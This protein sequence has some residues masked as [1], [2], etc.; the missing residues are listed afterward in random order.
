VVPRQFERADQNN[1]APRIGIAWDPTGTGRLSLRAGSGLFYDRPS[2][3]IYLNSSLNTPV[4]ARATASVLTPPVV[5]RF[6]LGRLDQPPYDFPLPPGVGPGLNEQN[7]LS[8]GARVMLVAADPQ[9]RT[10]YAVNWFAGVQYGLRSDWSVEANYL[11]S[12]GRRLYTAP[13]VNRFAGDLIVNNGVQQRLNRSFAEIEYGQ[14][15]GTSSFHGATV[16]VHKRFGSRLGWDAAYTFGKAI[17]QT[18]TFHPVG[19]AQLAVAEPNDLRRQRGLADFDV[20]HRWT[21]N[22]LW[23]LPAPPHWTAL[24]GGWQLSGVTMIQ[25][26]LPFSVVCTRP[27]AAVRD[28]G[29]RI[30]GNN[31]CDY[32]AD[33]YA[34]D[35]PDA[36]SARLPRSGWSRSQFLQG[37]FSPREFPAPSL[38]RQGTLGRNVF[39]GPGY[40]SADLALLKQIRLG[41]SRGDN[42]GLQVRAEAFNVLN[43]TNLQGVNGDLASPFFGRATSAFP[44]RT[45]QFA[46]RLAW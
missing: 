14:S 46:L 38:G 16:A 17:D 18:S 28:S 36:P 15:N 25:S 8:S 33:G 21:M 42:A 43:R 34:Y 12:L 45:L 10:Q 27:F 24:L 11:A 1:F 19:G 39:R 44:A 3:Q 37:V 30:V 13:D 31:G 7:G 40:A 2:D 9:F 26:G 32:N 35:F 20:R 6:A 41:W 29:G 22:F 5:P 23:R 4:I